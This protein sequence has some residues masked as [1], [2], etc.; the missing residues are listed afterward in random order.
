MFL[1]MALDDPI[2]AENVLRMTTA[3]KQ[4][5]VSCEL[6]LFPSGG[7]GYGLRPNKHEATRWPTQATLWLQSRGLLSE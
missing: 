4:A 7:H 5:K 6:H 1:T 3:L 2:D